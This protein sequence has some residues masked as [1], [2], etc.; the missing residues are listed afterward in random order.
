[1]V[2]FVGWFGFSVIPSHR[3]QVSSFKPAENRTLTI[4]E[5]YENADLDSDGDGLRDWEE[6]L[7]KTDPF[8]PDTDGDGTVDGREISDSRDPT[9]KGPDD[10]IKT[11]S[12]SAK[13][14]EHTAPITLT[15]QLAENFAVQYFSGKGATGGGNLPN[16]AKNYIADSL[17]IDIQKETLAHQNSYT[18]SDIKIVPA[19]EGENNKVAIKQ[20]LDSVGKALENNFKNIEGSEVK[21]MVSLVEP[22]PESRVNVL[23]PYISAYAKTAIFLKNEPVP[24]TYADLHLAL[25]NTMNNTRIAV[26]DMKLIKRDPAQAFVGMSLYL[27]ETSSAS[28]Y[29]N[30][31]NAQVNSDG[32]VFSNDDGGAFFNQYFSQPSNS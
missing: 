6:A 17:A 29:L 16:I 8:N 14:Q 23:D 4:T 12:D 26:E 5:A 19:V 9:V 28:I 11:L 18:A 7:W 30:N 25:L 15:E 13:S 24:E 20:Y 2:L 3:I 27:T 10:K 1:V 31:L 32:I 21:I 22:G